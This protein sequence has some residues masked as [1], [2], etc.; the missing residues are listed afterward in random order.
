MIALVTLERLARKHGP[1]TDEAHYAIRTLCQPLNEHQVLTLCR[2]VCQAMA[3][4]RVYPKLTGAAHTAK[5]ARLEC[6]HNAMHDTVMCVSCACLAPACGGDKV[7]ECCN[8]EL[9]RPRDS[10]HWCYV[11]VNHAG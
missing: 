7:H 4:E 9:G 8:A 10:E 3:A 1:L 2:E 5:L 6:V 11:C